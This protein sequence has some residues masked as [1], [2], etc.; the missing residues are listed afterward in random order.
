VGKAFGIL[1]TDLKL[2]SLSKFQVLWLYVRAKRDELLREKMD[3]DQ[4]KL[5]CSFINPEA[6]E[7][8]FKE[9]IVSVSDEFEQA[10]LERDP[11]FD[12]STFKK[13]MGDE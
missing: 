1:P 10:I 9:Q 4:A 13:M 5:I 7:K 12:M 6:A 3:T 11:N 8:V 2:R